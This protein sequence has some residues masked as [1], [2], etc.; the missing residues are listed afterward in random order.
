VESILPVIDTE[1]NT[2]GVP[3][4]HVAMGIFVHFPL[5]WTPWHLVPWPL[6]HNCPNQSD[7]QI[8]NINITTQEFV[9][10]GINLGT[11]WLLFYYWTSKLINVLLF[12]SFPNS[13]HLPANFPKYKGPGPQIQMSTY[14]T[15]VNANSNT[16]L[17]WARMTTKQFTKLT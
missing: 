4:C 9:I 8:A 14:C 15:K 7:S 17:W 6:E 3:H 10:V 11:V 2:L 16:F 13:H 1:L 12:R 5:K